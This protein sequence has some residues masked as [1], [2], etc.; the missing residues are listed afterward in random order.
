M[1]IGTDKD[2]MEQFGKLPGFCSAEK[3]EHML[4]IVRSEK[5]K[6]VIEVGVYGGRSLMPMALGVFR[7]GFG[8]VHG[9][10]AWRS[11]ACTEGEPDGWTEVWKTHDFEAVY[12]QFLKAACEPPF[13]GIIKIWREHLLKA[14]ELF[15]DQY[16][17]IVH[18]DG[19]HS[20]LIVGQ[21]VRLWAKKL[22]VGGVFV[23]DDPGWN[24][25]SSVVDLVHH[26]L[27]LKLVQDC[28]AYHV[29][30]KVAHV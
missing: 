7:N 11:D 15:A 28:N 6:Q 27:G 5:P 25:N 16:F 17:D 22:K 14:A 4:E 29:L 21:S 23:W 24:N 18:E 30:R 3:A 1:L 2:M 13:D 20:P 19:N 12:Q 8:T 26:G 9:V 10:D